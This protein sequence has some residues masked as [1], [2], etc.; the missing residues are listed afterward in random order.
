M[1]AV[2]DNCCFDCK[3]Q[4]GCTVKCEIKK[5]KHC[6]VEIEGCAGCSFFE[7]KKVDKD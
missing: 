6:P 2:P 3:I 7:E 1:L 5:R 4:K